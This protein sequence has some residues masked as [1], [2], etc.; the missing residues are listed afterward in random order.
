MLK[1]ILL[2]DNSITVKKLQ[3]ENDTS[4]NIW[5]G[6]ANQTITPLSQIGESQKA[7]NRSIIYNLLPDQ[8]KIHK[9]NSDCQFYTPSDPFMLL[10]PGNTSLEI[11]TGAN[12]AFRL[13]EL[14]IHKKYLQHLVPKEDIQYRLLSRDAREYVNH[15]TNICLQTKPAGSQ[16][17]EIY[18][19]AITIS[20]PEFFSSSEPSRLP[21]VDHKMQ[22][23]V[24]ILEE[25]L[26]SNLPS[27]AELAKS[28]GLS[29]ST[30]K[31]H[32]KQYT[33]ENIYQYYLQKKMELARKLLNDDKLSVGETA[34][35]LG[36]ANV[37][38]FIEIFKKFNGVS[39]GKL[40]SGKDS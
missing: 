35:I 29:V 2:A 16:V 21:T 33:G 30:L 6:L 28:S 12:I 11:A 13:I 5:Y 10:L 31:R 14:E 39:P 19:K 36:Y 18:D 24:I 22:S 32:F 17:R 20:L 27:L 34:E 4:I 40:K 7:G 26:R 37:S 38:N 9:I 23:I 8:L 15:L 25:N 3:L 1:E